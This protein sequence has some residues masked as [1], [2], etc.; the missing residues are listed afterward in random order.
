MGP[1]DQAQNEASDLFEDS[2]DIDRTHAH[3]HLDLSQLINGSNIGSKWRKES[4]VYWKCCSDTDT[5]RYNFVIVNQKED[6]LK[7]AQLE[8]P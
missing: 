5:T 3:Q 1:Q 7:Y 8:I 4:R 6:L 2:G